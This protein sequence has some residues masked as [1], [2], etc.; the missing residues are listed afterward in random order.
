[1]WRAH[2]ESGATVKDGAEAVARVRGQPA[3][4]SE[5]G[6]VA[7]HC[8][9]TRLSAGSGPRA[10]SG[11]PALARRGAISSNWVRGRSRCH[12]LQRGERVARV[13]PWIYLSWGLTLELCFQRSVS[14]GP[15]HPEPSPRHVST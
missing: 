2:D 4:C 1:M 3:A 11:R 14:I 8:D 15:V 6:G 10:G 12:R 7:A 5:R 13:E 9:V